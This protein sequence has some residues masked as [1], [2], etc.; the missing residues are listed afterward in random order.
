MR[1]AAATLHVRRNGKPS[2][3]LLRGDALH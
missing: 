2:A 3:Q 1:A